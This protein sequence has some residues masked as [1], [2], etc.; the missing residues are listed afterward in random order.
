MSENIVESRRRQLTRAAALGGVFLASRNARADSAGAAG[1][2]LNVRQFGAKGDGKSDD[3]K[4]IQSAIDGAASRGGAVYL[5]P[6]VYRTGELQLRPHV[7]LTGVPA[8]DYEHGFGSVLR[9]ADAH[10]GCLLNITG[11]FGATIDGLAL[12]GGKLGAGV[13]GIWLNKP[14]YGKQEDAFRIERSQIANFTGDGV[15]LTRAWCFSIR[16]SMIAYNAGDGISLRGWD[17]FLLDNWLS[18]NG[19]AGFGAREENASCT[20]TGNRIEWNREGVIL[21]GGNGYNITGNFFDRAGTS[22]LAILGGMQMTVTGN[23][24]KRSGKIAAPRSHES[25]QIRLEG[26]R[27]ITCCGNNLQAGRDD[28]EKGVWSPSYGIVYKELRNCVIANNVLDEGALDR[29]LLDL[30]GHGEGAVVKDNPGSLS[31]HQG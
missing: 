9:L 25:S 21:V 13:H 24:F 6:G 14:D 27:G 20:L 3:T 28:G 8:W 2:D 29:L 18:G 26:V 22:A 23:L 4:S 15:R 16:H 11:A 17:G 10:A 31:A 1:I 30:G 19:G 12:D 5:P 7:S